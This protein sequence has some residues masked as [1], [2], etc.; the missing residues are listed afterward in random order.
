[1]DKEDKYE[2]IRHIRLGMTVDLSSGSYISKGTL[3]PYLKYQRDFRNLEN[4][5]NSKEFIDIR[6]ED[7]INCLD[8]L[9]NKITQLTFFYPKKE[10]DLQARMDNPLKV[11]DFIKDIHNPKFVVSSDFVKFGNQYLGSDT[12]VDESPGF[13]PKFDFSLKPKINIKIM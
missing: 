8:F 9:T 11:L 2:D 10:K 13:K 5:Y 4:Y 12:L 3:G 7:L 6:L 1:M